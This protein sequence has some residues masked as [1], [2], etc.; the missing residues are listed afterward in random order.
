MKFLLY[1]NLQVLKIVVKTARVLEQ[2]HELPV[3]V[4]EQ[5]PELEPESFAV[6]AWLTYFESSA[7]G[8]AGPGTI[9]HYKLA[10][11]AGFHPH[12]LLHRV[13]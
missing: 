12:S 3:H 10:D 9:S 2:G 6:L 11:Q 4:L 1:R 5:V 8:P 7:F 13:T